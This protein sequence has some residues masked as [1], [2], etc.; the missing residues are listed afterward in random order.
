VVDEITE[1][2]WAAAEAAYPRTPENLARR[3][4]YMRQQITTNP[5]HGVT[6]DQ[7]AELLD[8]KNGTQLRA[9][10]AFNG[11]DVDHRLVAA[12]VAKLIIQ[13]SVGDVLDSPEN[14][15]R[16]H[17]R[18]GPA[19]QDVP[20]TRAS[21]APVADPTAPVAVSQW[22]ADVGKMEYGRVLGWA[23]ASLRV[24]WSDGYVARVDPDDVH[25]LTAEKK[26]RETEM[27]IRDAYDELAENKG[28]GVGI[29]QIREKMPDVSKEDFDAAAHNVMQHSDVNPDPLLPLPR[30]FDKRTS[31]DLEN[32]VPLGGSTMM[33][34]RMHDR[35]GYR[36][37]KDDAQRW[38]AADADQ[39]ASYVATLND[40]EVRRL[41]ENIGVT[42]SEDPDVTAARI[43]ETSA[44]NRDEWIANAKQSTAD[45]TALHDAEKA[46]EKGF[47]PDTWTAEERAE[48][49][50]AARRQAGNEW[51]PG[52]ARAAKFIDLPE[53]GSL[54]PVWSAKLKDREEERDIR[55]AA[56][57]TGQVYIDHD[58]EGTEHCS[59]GRRHAGACPPATEGADGNCTL[60]DTDVNVN[61]T[62]KVCQRCTSDR[63]A[64]DG[65]PFRPGD[66]TGIPPH[67][68]QRCG[69]CRKYMTILAGTQHFDADGHA[70]V[71]TS[72]NNCKIASGVTWTWSTGEPPATD[73]D[74]CDDCG[75]NP[76]LGHGPRCSKA[77]RD[78]VAE[79]FAGTPLPQLELRFNEIVRLHNEMYDGLIKQFEQRQK[80][81]DAI[82]E[83]GD[84]IDGMEAAT[85]DL[86][87]KAAALVAEMKTARFDAAS[88]AGCTEAAEALTAEDV[89]EMCD[90]LD[91]T[92]DL[93]CEGTGRV[94]AAADAVEASIR[95]VE[96]TYGA[97]AAGIQETGVSGKALEGAGTAS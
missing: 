21:S 12:D 43:V 1:E 68:K 65:Q 2:Q 89:T 55:K 34:I 72:C 4:Q 31:E 30:S 94:A 29:R 61:P 58:L 53:D 48:I 69:R 37:G 56:S 6:R 63:A 18:G 88:I 22:N 92:G 46:M 96:S 85:G 17:I 3:F 7:V 11:I 50:A 67:V 81:R 62:T 59:A 44:R 78:A 14:A 75:R 40:D 82:G 90:A 8:G 79:K 73:Q 66:M 35:R 95:H 47:S 76:R 64:Y 24:E 23:G 39:V 33:T 49:A 93:V 15:R 80:V 74:I 25:V 91:I 86:Q 41:A 54:G 52:A 70:S 38:R 57:E 97:L 16:P 77:E 71:S 19:A 5:D 32:G 20:V 51:E 27:R 84:A 45:L 9:V 28:D 10:A 83:I 60:C 87:V 26:R 42:P 13:R 36:G